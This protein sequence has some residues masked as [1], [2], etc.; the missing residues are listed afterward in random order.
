MTDIRRTRTIAASADDI[1]N[2]LADFGSLSSWSGNVDHSCVLHSGP[3]G[4]PVG[5]ARR[6]QVKR[7]ALVERITEFDPGRALAYDIEGLPRRLRRVRNRWT[8]APA[9]AASVHAT[10]V[11]VTSTV[12]IGPRATHKLAERALC[13]FLARQS[14]ALLAGLANRLENGRA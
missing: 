5:T 11:T 6:V 2:V 12:E 7:E 10:V 13:H 8:L 14:D 9:G 4:G 3:D 1:W